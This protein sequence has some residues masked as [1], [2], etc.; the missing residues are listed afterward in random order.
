[1]T[2]FTGEL[3]EWR[4]DG[5]WPA[6]EPGT[7]AQPPAMQPAHADQ[8]VTATSFHSG[9]PLSWC[10]DAPALPEQPWVQRRFLFWKR[11]SDVAL[12]LG[13]GIVLGPM[14]LLCALAVRLSSP[15]PALFTQERTGVG[16]GEVSGGEVADDGGGAGDMV[17]P[18]SA[19][20][21]HRRTATI[22]ERAQG[23]D[24]DRR[25]AP[26]PGGDAGGGAAL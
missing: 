15:G 2:E 24:G 17:R 18:F 21:Q 1:M 8:R 5:I 23:R 26:A 9:L 7:V 16:G 25:A 22:A 19:A 6:A 13:A 12:A 11:A 10:G 4:N 20:H 14:L 3:A